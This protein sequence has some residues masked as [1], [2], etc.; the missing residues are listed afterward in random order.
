MRN[1]RAVPGWS[2]LS[3]SQSK[4][5]QESILQTVKHCAF[6]A[7]ASYLWMFSVSQG[8]YC[9]L[10]IQCLSLT[11]CPEGD[12]L[13][14]FTFLWQ[15]RGPE[16]RSRLSVGG[17]PAGNKQTFWHRGHPKAWS[18]LTLNS[19]FRFS[20]G[21]GVSWGSSAGSVQL[22]KAASKPTYDS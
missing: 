14:S 15:D 17:H 10:G 2:I 18:P 16:R 22:G 13:L 20:V 19:N 9:V 21:S 11:R 1:L 5:D 12:L 4:G 6:L 8:R 3:F 7:I